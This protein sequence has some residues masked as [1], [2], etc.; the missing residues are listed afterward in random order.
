MKCL[1]FFTLMGLCTRLSLGQLNR[2]P[3]DYLRHFGAMTKA[4]WI[5]MNRNASTIRV[6]ILSGAHKELRMSSEF[7]EWKI[8][9]ML[10]KVDYALTSK[11]QA[12]TWLNNKCGLNFINWL[13][14]LLPD[15]QIICYFLQELEAIRKRF[16]WSMTFHSAIDSLM[17]HQL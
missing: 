3:E 7:V 4:N 15:F 8:L 6:L 10:C 2:I 13:S 12:Q 9:W 1:A 11:Q 16:S 17:P 5:Q 14:L